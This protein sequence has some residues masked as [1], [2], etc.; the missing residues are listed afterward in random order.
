MG[1]TFRGGVHPEEMKRLTGDIPIKK[2]KVPRKVV[3]PLSQHTGGICRPLVKA[4]DTVRLGDKIGE[5]DKFISSP[6]HA[7]ISGTITAVGDFPHP[8]LGTCAAVTI[9]R[10]E[11]TDEGWMKKPLSAEAIAK[12]TAEELRDKV[13]AAGI[14]GLGGAAFPTHVKI[15]PPAGKPIDTFMLNGAECEPYL[16]CDYR[17]MLE[18]PAEIV[19]G[20][21]L[22]MKALGVKKGYVG[23]EDNKPAAIRAMEQAAAGIDSP[24]LEVAVLKT[25][26]PQ[27]SEKQLIKALLNREV[28]AGGLP[29]DVGVVVDNVGTAFAVWEA[30]SMEKPLYER[31]V[32]VTGKTVRRP[33]NFLV[34]IG[35]LMSELIEECGGLTGEPGKVIMGGP[36]M[37]IAQYTLD[38]PVVKGTSGI[39]VLARGKPEKRFP[40]VKCGA[41]VEVCPMHLMPC[42][43][44]EFAEQDRFAE[45]A[46]YRVNDCMECGACAYSCISNRPIVHLIKYAKLNLAKAKKP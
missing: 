17:L 18:R 2:M 10:K 39:V 38:I 1:F 32:T 11:E 31:V 22:L 40:C 20:A 45:C 37:G 5:S 33:G 30:V 12:F 34:R 27:G 26:Y 36:M 21:T 35:T 28:P 24:G 13:R 9:E 6:I 42:R 16:T 19:R 29:L 7:S 43:I 15:A 41:C 14:V 46:E 25:K 23:I 44:A 4:G 8:V 3:I